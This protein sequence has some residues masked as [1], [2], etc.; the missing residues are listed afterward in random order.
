MKELIK[1]FYYGIF[2][3][4]EFGVGDKMPK[5]KCLSDL[6]SLDVFKA[7]NQ[8]KFLDLLMNRLKDK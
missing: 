2:Y 3:D 7:K 1:S 6:D 8:I 5:G 4:K